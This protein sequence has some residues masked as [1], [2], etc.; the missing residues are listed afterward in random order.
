MQSIHHAWRMTRPLLLALALAA[1]AGCGS[2]ATSSAA[3]STPPGAKASPTP[4]TV[5]SSARSTAAPTS[6]TSGTS[7]PTRSVDVSAAVQSVLALFQRVPRNPNNPAAGYLWVPATATADYL[8]RPVNTRLATLRS[9]GYFSDRVCGVDYI[10][11]TQNGLSA[12]PKVVSTH[13]NANGSVTIVVQRSATP[14]PPNLTV[15][16]TDQNGVWRASDLATGAGLSASIFS[17]KPNC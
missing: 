9:N 2:G 17:A 14:P 11:G 3:G 7:G 1:L 10:T 12:T 6:P 8:S 4:P 15:V 16:M 5:S 13:S